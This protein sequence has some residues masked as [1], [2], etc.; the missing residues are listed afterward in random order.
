MAR[1]RESPRCR[2]VAFDVVVLRV[3]GRD[4]DEDSIRILGIL[5]FARHPVVKL[6]SNRLLLLLWGLN[7]NSDGDLPAG[8]ERNLDGLLRL[9]GFLLHLLLH[10]SHLPNGC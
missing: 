6:F 5:E 9:L 3:I 8:I 7:L 2:D 4:I 1:E 10:P